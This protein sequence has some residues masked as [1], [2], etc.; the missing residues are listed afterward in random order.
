MPQ[1]AWT[2]RAY[3]CSNKLGFLPTSLV[4]SQSVRPACLQ[5][6]RAHPIQVTIREAAKRAKK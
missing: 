2:V 4:L 6:P 1:L 5:K 3:T